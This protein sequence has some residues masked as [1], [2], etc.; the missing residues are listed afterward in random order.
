MRQVEVDIME[1]YFHL[2]E[3]DMCT[4]QP[5]PTNDLPLIY[6]RCVFNVKAKSHALEDQR[7]FLLVTKRI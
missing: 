1:G 6:S 2:H 7:K 3:Q 5:F 4:L